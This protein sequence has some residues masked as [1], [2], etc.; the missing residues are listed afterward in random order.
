MKNREI[1]TVADFAEFSRTTRDTLLHYDK[2]GLL[3]PELRG[4][5][6]YR[7]YS[8]GQLAVINLIRTCQAFG[9]TLSEIKSLTKNR[10]PELIDGLLE[11][12]MG[13]IDDKIEEWV[14]AR[15][16]LLTLKNS[17]HST[18]NVQDN[19]ISIKFIE[20]EAIILGDL[21]DY[22]RGR[23]DYDALLSFY[24]SSK[25]K[26]PGLDMNYPV[27]AMFSEERLKKRDFM[28]PDRYYFFNPEGHDKRPAALYAI[29]YKRN[30]YGKSGDLYERMLDYIEENNFEVC[31][32]AYEEYPQ[33]EVSIIDENNYLMRV[34]ITVREKSPGKKSI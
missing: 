5:N 24:N 18:L 12:Q 29:A 2:I 3:M 26:Y 17:I 25:E 34:M 6:N 32:P 15:K 8:N 31:G 21:N 14:R 9:M 27:W 30:G 28:W 10:T 1:F 7:Y 22:S 11:Q 13:L 23:T 4:E 33:N 19:V 16:L 20:R